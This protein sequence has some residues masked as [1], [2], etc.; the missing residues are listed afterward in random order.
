MEM[1]K[2]EWSGITLRFLN[3]EFRML[4]RKK[5]FLFFEERLTSV[6]ELENMSYLWDSQVEILKKAFG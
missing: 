2:R 1:A 3:L 6:L 4:C 5:W